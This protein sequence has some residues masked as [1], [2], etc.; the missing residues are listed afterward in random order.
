MDRPSHAGL[1]WERL[2]RP[3][4]NWERATGL[5]A[6]VIDQFGHPLKGQPGAKLRDEA[7]RALTGDAVELAA[8][9]DQAGRQ[10]SRDGKYFC[11]PVRAGRRTVGWVIGTDPGEHPNPRRVAA[12]ADMLRD[13]LE[14]GLRPSNPIAARKSELELVAI[15][16]IV[17]QIVSF[18]EVAPLLVYILDAS[19]GF[20]G[21]SSGSLMLL[22]KGSRE[23]RIA[24]A[25]HLPPDAHDEDDRTGIARYVIERRQPLLLVGEIDPGQMPGLEIHYTK[26]VGYSMC[27]PI[28]TRS[29]VLGVLNINVGAPAA[30]SDRQLIFLQLMADQAAVAI[31]NARIYE[32]LRDK[33]Q[34]LELLLR[35]IID[36][37]EEE[38]ERICLEIHDGIAQILVSAHQRLQT[39][40]RLAS[41][42]EG[43]PGE[44]FNR[45][46][47]LVRQS[48][49]ESRA[50]IDNLHPLTLS[51]LG[52][53]ATLE[54]EAS[55]LAVDQGWNLDWRYE[56]GDLKLDKSLEIALYRMVQE[57]LSN[58][59]K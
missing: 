58:A 16:Q 30:P 8:A 45:A 5:R 36:A 18:H 51:D 57:A 53:G 47:G 49:A 25:R 27:L 39:Y 14:S 15:A 13:V 32:E 48:I 54:H 50:L 9:L 3:L 24:A 1:Q 40:A 28:A 7:V 10:P 33:E 20:A 43:P 46:V 34:R 38:R 6:W 22:D 2:E 29:E 21:G 55:A 35:N 37:Q 41:P 42:P 56:L 19:L 11:R 52:L 17:Q 4:T 31:N 12:A 44:A 23:L 26:Q 59:K